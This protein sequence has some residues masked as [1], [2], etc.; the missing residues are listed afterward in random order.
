MMKR[1]IKYLVEF[2]YDEENDQI[3]DVPIKG[4]RTLEDVY[5]KCNVAIAEPSCLQDAMNSEEWKTTM[6]E[7]LNMIEKNATWKLVDKP[8]NKNVIGVKWVYKVKLNS[9]GSLNKYKARL[10]VKGHSQLAGID[11]TETFAPVARFDTIRLLFAMVAQKGWLIYQLDVKSA[12][13]NGELKEEIYVEQ[14]DG[15]VKKE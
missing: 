3:D 13:L 2:E 4:T 6:Q 11:F 8:T 1:M 14:P 15:Y 9:H 10:V 5:S 12:F 7:E